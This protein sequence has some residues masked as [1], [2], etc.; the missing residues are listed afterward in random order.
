VTWSDLDTWCG[1]ETINYPVFVGHKVGLL[2]SGGR[3]HIEDNVAHSVCLEDVQNRLMKH[4]LV[5][6]TTN[7]NLVPSL[8]PRGEGISKVFAE[9]KPYRTVIMGLL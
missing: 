4:G 6:I 5:Y 8:W 9:C 7:N 2:E 3:V 1:P